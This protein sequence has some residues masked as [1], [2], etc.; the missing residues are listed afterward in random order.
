MK[1]ILGPNE[2]L[3]LE[4]IN[5]KMHVAKRSYTEKHPSVKVSSYAPVRQEVLGYI[6]GAGKVTESDLK[7]F[8]RMVTEKTGKKTSMQWVAKNEKYLHIREK[9]G[10]KTYQL[11]RLGEK[12][13]KMHKGI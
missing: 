10:I 5:E 3:L 2:F 4:S 11:N 8:F 6:S 7:E 13:L 9:Q 1:H 12:V